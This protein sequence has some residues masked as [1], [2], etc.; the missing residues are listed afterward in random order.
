MNTTTILIIGAIL[1]GIGLGYFIARL[2]RRF[3]L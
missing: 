2:L 3:D 1:F